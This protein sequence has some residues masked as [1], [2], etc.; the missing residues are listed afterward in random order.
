MRGVNFS[1][2]A[3]R[4]LQTSGF[5]LTKKITIGVYLSAKLSLL[6]P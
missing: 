5:E 6:G 2:D 3:A 1:S 4:S